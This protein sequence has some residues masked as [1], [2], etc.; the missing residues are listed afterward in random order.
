ML[1]AGLGVRRALTGPCALCNR[2]VQSR[3]RDFAASTHTMIPQVVV[4][5]VQ[6]STPRLAVMMGG[7]CG[8]SLLLYLFVGLAGAPSSASAAAIANLDRHRCCA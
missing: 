5:L 6:P 8:G 2:I 7:V 3:R 4:E 1:A